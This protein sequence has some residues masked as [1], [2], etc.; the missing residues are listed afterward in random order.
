MSKPTCQFSFNL[1]IK[2]AEYIEELSKN[3]N[4]RPSET[5]KM[6]LEQRIE[7]E[8]R[9]WAINDSILRKKIVKLIREENNARN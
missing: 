3:F 6:M 4:L 7:L 8:M 1:Q 2:V 5:A 9:G